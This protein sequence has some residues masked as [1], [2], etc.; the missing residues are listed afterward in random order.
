MNDG[1]KANV[2]TWLNT[3]KQKRKKRLNDGS[4]TTESPEEQ[5]L[6]EIGILWEVKKAKVK[7]R[8]RKYIAEIVEYKKKWEMEHPGKKW[9]GRVPRR[10]SVTLNDGTKAN[11]GRWLDDQKKKRKKRL[12]DRSNTTESPQEKRLNEIGILWEVVWKKK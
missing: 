11:V 12:N 2:G 5:R 10:Y 1:T 4:N 6:N 7:D 3:Q 8:K 9:D